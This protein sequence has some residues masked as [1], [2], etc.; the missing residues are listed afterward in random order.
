M[1]S[2][3]R[4]I[5]LGHL[6]R[7]PKLSYLPSQVPVVDF[8]IATNRVWYDAD[9]KKR[10]DV[11]FIDCRCFGARAETINK[12]MKKGMPLLIEGRLEQDQWEAADGTKRSKHRV[13]IEKFTFVG[14]QKEAQPET[15]T[16]PP[17]DNA[18]EVAPD[19]GE[20]PF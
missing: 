5:L 14:G 11:C 6:S 2:Y 1:S 17:A 7:D 20:I 18:D 13:F 15:S 12:Y 3:N 8:A 16:A 19:G 10:E 4:I 9:K